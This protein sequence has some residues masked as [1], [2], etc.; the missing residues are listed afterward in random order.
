MFCSKSLHILHA[1]IFIF[2]I[3]ICWLHLSKLLSTS[4]FIAPSAPKIQMHCIVS[5]GFL[6]SPRLMSKVPENHFLK[7]SL[8]FVL[9]VQTTD[10]HLPRVHT[11]KFE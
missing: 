10:L 8:A 3:E 6:I 2:S 11:F 1:Y 5:V 7:H 9:V 4:I